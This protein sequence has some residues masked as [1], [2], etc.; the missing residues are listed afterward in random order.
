MSVQGVIDSLRNLSTPDVQTVRQVAEEI[1]VERDKPVKLWRL[2]ID[3]LV[4]DFER[5][6]EAVAYVQM[7]IL[8]CLSL[9]T[10][11]AINLHAHDVPA[12]QVAELINRETVKKQFLRTN[13]ALC[14]VSV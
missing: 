2:N 7:H 12:S 3:G 6:D 8:E 10:R 4:G 9:Q 11:I 1:E 14:G 13:M 5:Y